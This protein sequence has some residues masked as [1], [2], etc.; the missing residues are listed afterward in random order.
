MQQSH[1]PTRSVSELKAPAPWRLLGGLGSS[2]AAGIAM[3]KLIRGPLKRQVHAFDSVLFK[4]TR[5]IESPFLD[6]VMAILS[7]LGEP[8]LLYSLAGTSALIWLVKGRGR[9]S[10]ALGFAVLGSATIDKVTKATIHR[11]RPYLKLPLARSRPSGSSFPSNHAMMSLAMYGTLAS[12]SGSKRHSAHSPDTSRKIY[13]QSAI[14]RVPLI[15]PKP[16]DETAEPRRSL[17]KRSDTPDRYSRNRARK[18]KVRIGLALALSALVGWSRV[19]RGVHNPSDVIAGWM[20][21]GF[22]LLVCY[23]WRGNG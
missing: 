16:D 3:G 10:A 2:C 4:A 21:G 23:S 19:Y 13:S 18:R 12:L 22:W 17:G 1:T 6:R 7:E 5:K 11:P 14:V 15:L 20:L 8:S 9:D